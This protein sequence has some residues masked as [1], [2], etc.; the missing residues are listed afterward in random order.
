M[1]WPP[2]IVKLGASEGNGTLE[3][4]RAKAIMSLATA[5]HFYIVVTGLRNQLNVG[6]LRA[7]PT[8]RRTSLSLAWQAGRTQ[9]G[10]DRER[11]QRWKLQTLQ[12]P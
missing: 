9:F 3:R 5:M 2:V 12:G 1:G 8:V 10:S 7:G 4:Y 11:R 6:G